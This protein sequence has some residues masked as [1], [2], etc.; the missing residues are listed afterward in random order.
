MLNLHLTFAVYPSLMN[1]EPES[2]LASLGG[3]NGSYCEIAKVGDAVDH[4]GNKKI[5]YDCAQSNQ[6]CPLISLVEFDPKCTHPG[7][8]QPALD[9]HHTY[10]ARTKNS[11]SFFP[12]HLA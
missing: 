5:R 8:D 1:F 6:Q 4:K 12:G 7:R 9:Y 11:P 10:R 3:T 2:G